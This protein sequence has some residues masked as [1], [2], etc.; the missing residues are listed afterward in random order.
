MNI[1]ENII[2]LNAALPDEEITA[3]IEKIK[4][5]II[6]SGGEVLKTEAWGRKKLSY[7]I[8]KQNKGFYTLL[9]YKTPPVTI[10]KLEN[11]FKVFDPVIKFMIIKLGS[12]QIKHFEAVQTAESEQSKSEE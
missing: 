8:K 9:I 10:K 7:E 11:F 12:K 4:D 2:I 6:N 5:I 1:Y 3:S